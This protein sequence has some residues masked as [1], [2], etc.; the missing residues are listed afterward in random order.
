MLPIVW[1]WEARADLA[2][3]LGYIGDRNPAAAHRMQDIIQEA[4]E[5]LAAFPLAGRAGRVPGTRELVAHPNYVIVYRVE[6]D[7]VRVTNV[8]H[9]RQQYP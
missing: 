2:E 6:I 3:L 4:V 7:Q 1:A 5:G 9:A 8:L